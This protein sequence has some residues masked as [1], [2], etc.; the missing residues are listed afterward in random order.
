MDTEKRDF[1]TNLTLTERIGRLEQ[2]AG[3]GAGGMPGN[4]KVR[5]DVL[6]N[7]PPLGEIQKKY[8]HRQS[9]SCGDEDE[10]TEMVS[11]FE[12]IIHR[13]HK[14]AERVNERAEKLEEIGNRVFGHLPEGAS[15]AEKSSISSGGMSGATFTALDVL[16]SALGRLDAAARRLERV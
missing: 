2:L 7:F 5:F 15:G 6:H 3:I 14:A 13:V 9:Q 10:R 8:N 4:E 16:D 1:H 12:E 11:T